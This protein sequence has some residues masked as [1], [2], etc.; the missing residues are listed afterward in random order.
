[1][2][3]SGSGPDETAQPVGDSSAW[4]TV[5]ERKAVERRAARKRKRRLIRTGQVLLVLA[6][7]MALTHVL[8]HQQAFGGQPSGLVDLLAGYPMASVLGLA[9]AVLAGQ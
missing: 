6:A 3:T 8:M 5:A 1:M 4:L 9:G 7:L 2:V